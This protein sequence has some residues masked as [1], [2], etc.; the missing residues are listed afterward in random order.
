MSKE[1][2]NNNRGGKMKEKPVWK[3]KKLKPC[4]AGRA[5]VVEG[6]TDEEEAADKEA[7]IK[8]RNKKACSVKVEVKRNDVI[9]DIF[10]TLDMD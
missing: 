5:Y 9:T 1:K 10:I 7:L 8:K 2:L 4:K 3:G 6:W